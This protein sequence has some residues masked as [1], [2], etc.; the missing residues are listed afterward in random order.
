MATRSPAENLLREVSCSIC[1]EYFR[2]PVSIHCGH[3]FC[4]GCISRC[5]EWS[6][7]TF[8]CP[9]C[10]RT[11][12]ER[13]FRPN[14]EL[15]RVL[16]AAKRLSLEAAPEDPGGCRKHWEPLRVFCKEDAA[17]LCGVCRE[18][19]AHRAHTVLPMTEAAEEFKGQIQARVQILKEE[20]DQLLATREAEMGRNWEYLEQTGAERRRIQSQF[21]RLRLFL[22]DQERRLLAQLGQLDGDVEKRQEENVTRLTEEISRLDTLIQDMEEKC[23]QP[24]REFLQVRKLGAQGSPV[25]ASRMSFGSRATFPLPSLRIPHSWSFPV[26]LSGHRKRLEQ[27][28]GPSPVFCLLPAKVTLDPTTAHAQLAVSADGSSVRW[29][30]ARGDPADAELG[31]DPCVLGHQGIVSGWLCWDVEV[32]P[33][34]SW[35]VG[36]TKEPARSGDGSDTGALWSMGLCEGRFWALSSSERTALS[37]ERLPRRV[38]VCLDYEGGQVA[39]FDADTKSLI[40]AF[41]AA[42]FHGESI[43]PWFL[44]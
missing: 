40:F 23:Q 39:F 3:N 34:G 7:G 20:R 19:R 26:S 4:R 29:E 28:V 8:P 33:K 41:P 36:V 17:L 5:W 22:E 43:R 31:A 16:E 21:E 27:A 13:S 11:A 1:L 32:E 15:E 2:D 24:A 6:T 37:R 30:E 10:R 12:P 25:S 42:S 9:R 18:S 14:R 44:V 38:R 35:A